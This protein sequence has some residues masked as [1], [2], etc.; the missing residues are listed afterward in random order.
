MPTSIPIPHIKFG[1]RKERSQMCEIFTDDGR[2]VD[3]E[4][5]AYSS[6]VADENTRLAFLL[7]SA[8]Q[9]RAEDGNDHQLLTEKTS[10]PLRLRVASKY[11]N[12][13]NDQE[14]M[15]TLR[16]S[17]FK[18]VFRQKQTEGIDE[19]K[20]QTAMEVLYKIVIV[21]SATI[22]VIVGIRWISGGMG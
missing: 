4:Y 22:L 17:I 21:I 5:P 1:K 8:N 18:M 15:K 9:Y 11:Q 19:V 16:N 10:I 12:G 3:K 2:W 13:D 6:C 20:K 14:E 7:D